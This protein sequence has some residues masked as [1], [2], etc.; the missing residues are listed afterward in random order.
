MIAQDDKK[1]WVERSIITKFQVVSFMLAWEK[2]Y[3]VWN[4][5]TTR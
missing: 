4:A 2:S 3:M 1:A 5:T